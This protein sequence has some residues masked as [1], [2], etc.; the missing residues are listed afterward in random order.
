MYTWVR[1]P[2]SLPSTF[3]HVAHAHCPGPAAMYPPAPATATSTLRRF[4]TGAGT[5]AAA[6]AASSSF[7]GGGGIAG[8]LS[9]AAANRR[10]RFPSAPAVGPAASEARRKQ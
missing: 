7:A 6:A 5:G 3:P 10:K 1:A 9:A 4:C 2:R 8:A